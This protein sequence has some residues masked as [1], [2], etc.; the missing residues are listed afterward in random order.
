[1]R[2]AF[3]EKKSVKGYSKVITRLKGDGKNYQFRIKHKASD[4][5]S[6]ISEFTT[7]G[8]WQTVEIRL[9][10]MYPTFR[11]RKLN[12]PDFSADFIEEIRFLIGNK[13]PQEFELLIDKIALG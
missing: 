3:P 8:N 2:Y 10:D 9:S 13:K 12:I 11:G 4:Y 1:M 5:Q 7:T 6:Y